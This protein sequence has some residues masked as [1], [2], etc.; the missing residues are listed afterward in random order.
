MDVATIRSCVAGTLDAD[1]DVRRRAELQLKQVSVPLCAHRCVRDAYPSGSP[2]RPTSIP[3][4]RPR[5]P[6][7]PPPRPRCLGPLAPHGRRSL[8]AIYSPLRRC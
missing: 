2:T 1:A 8:Q 3:L 5:R 4:A 7:L 6:A